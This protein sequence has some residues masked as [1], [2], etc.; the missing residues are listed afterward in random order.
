MGIRRIGWG[1]AAQAHSQSVAVLLQ[2]A[3]TPLVMARLTAE[4]WPSL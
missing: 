3:A 2:V 4:T 1:V